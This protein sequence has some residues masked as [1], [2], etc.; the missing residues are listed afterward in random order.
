MNS[1][2]RASLG[3][4]SVRGRSRQVTWRADPSTSPGGPIPSRSTGASR[5]ANRRPRDRACEPALTS[6]R[7]L[8]SHRDEERWPHMPMTKETAKVLSELMLKIGK[9]LEQ[10]LHLVKATET[11]E[12]FKRYRSV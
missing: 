8:A 10:S 12:V 6:L 9:D 1:S 2:D 11:D 5:S 7:G 4:S 3:G